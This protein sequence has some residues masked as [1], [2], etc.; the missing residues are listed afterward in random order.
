MVLETIH[1]KHPGQAEILA[2][3]KFKWYPHIHSDFVA[4]AQS[5]RHC[6]DKGENLKSLILKTQLGKL[7]PLSEPNG[8]VQMKF[9]GPIPFKNNVQSKY[10][11]VTVDRLS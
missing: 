5:C 6:T 11:L 1:N 10:I 2:L 4:Q 3:A 9:A 7:P 8:E